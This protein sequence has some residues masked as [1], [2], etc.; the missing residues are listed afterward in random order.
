MNCVAAIQIALAPVFI[1]KIQDNQIH[2]IEAMG[3]IVCCASQAEWL[4]ILQ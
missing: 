1:F 3:G 4:V 2:E